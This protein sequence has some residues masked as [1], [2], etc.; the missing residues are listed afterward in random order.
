MPINS[1]KAE[2]SAIP[3]LAYKLI[4]GIPLA[5]SGKSVFYDRKRRAHGG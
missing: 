2:G 1:K 3:S 5:V 4:M